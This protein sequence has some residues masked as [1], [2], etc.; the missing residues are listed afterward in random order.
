MIYVGKLQILNGG[1]G[2]KGCGLLYT[3][4]FPLYSLSMCT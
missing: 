4:L 3:V 2:P 1:A